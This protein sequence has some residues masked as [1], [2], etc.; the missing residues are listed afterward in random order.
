MPWVVVIENIESGKMELMR[1]DMPIDPDHPRYGQEAHIVPC[2][3]GDIVDQFNFSFGAHEF[4]RAC[5]CH[6]EVCEQVYGRR[7]VIHR[8]ATN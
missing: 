5:Y 7:L 3:E 6:P 4:T 2:N 8:P 1:N